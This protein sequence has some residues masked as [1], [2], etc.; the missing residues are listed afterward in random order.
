MGFIQIADNQV[1]KNSNLYLLGLAIFRGNCPNNQKSFFLN[2][3]SL[4]K[5]TLIFPDIL[6]DF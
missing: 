1:P 2:S 3:H 5:K 4:T 6:P